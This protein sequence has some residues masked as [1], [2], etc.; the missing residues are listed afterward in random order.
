MKQEEFKDFALDDLLIK[1]TVDDD[2]EPFN[3]MLIHYMH[4][5]KGFAS[6]WFKYESFGSDEFRVVDLARRG[7]SIEDIKKY[8]LQPL[9]NSEIKIKK[10]KYKD[11]MEQLQYIPP[12]HHEFY[13]SLKSC[14]CKDVE[15]CSCY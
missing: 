15:S 7:K 10:Q 12:V 9:Y 5:R 6:M 2:R 1:R 11:L 14:K 4:F 13:K 8:K 3:W